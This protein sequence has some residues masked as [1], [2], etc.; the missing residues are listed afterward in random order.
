MTELRI[1]DRPGYFGSKRDGILEKYN[2]TYG[3][4]NWNISWVVGPNL[5]WT[6]GENPV[7][8]KY[9]VFDYPRI[10]K[11]Y[12]DAYYTYFEN[13]PEEL[14]L[15]IQN[16][17]EVYDNHESNVESGL[18]YEKQEPGIGT[19]IQDITIR[20]VV[21]RFGRQFEGEMLLQIRST[22]RQ[23]KKWSPMQIPFHRPEWILRPK[24]IG[25]WDRGVENSVEC[26]YQS[27][28]VLMVRK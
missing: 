11:L 7:Q 9:V 19:H 26:F 8:G 23:G 4:G 2:Q 16:A 15:I 10:C 14:E 27:N 25:W 24:V 18:N 22:S 5:M 21:A 3:K 1:A 20:N 12:E 13:H 28:K 6:G 17:S